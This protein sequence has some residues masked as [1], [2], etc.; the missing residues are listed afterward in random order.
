MPKSITACNCTLCRRYGALW[1]YGE[2]DQNMVV[3]GKTKYFERGSKINGYNFCET[4]GC[5]VYYLAHKKN[6]KG[7]HRMAINLRTIHDP[8]LVESLPIDHFDGL[9]KFDDL[10]RDH[11]TVKDL[12]F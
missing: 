10:P 6:E 8:S 2:K 3:A 4:C 9:D 1:T 12:W 5:V 11:R 7:H